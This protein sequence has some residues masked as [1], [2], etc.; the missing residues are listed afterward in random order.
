MFGYLVQRDYFQLL[1][2]MLDEKVPPLD[3]PVTVPP[4]S[5]SETLLQMIVHPLKL[6][7]S[8]TGCSRFILI[9]FVEQIL[10]PS[11][12]DPIRSFVLPCL[13]I[14]PN[15]PFLHLIQFLLSVVSQRPAAP[16]DNNMDTDQA[17]L[18]DTNTTEEELSKKFTGSAFLL[19][20]LLTLDVNRQQQEL[21]VPQ[22]LAIYIRVVAAMSINLN[23]MPAS[24]VARHRGNQSGREDGGV[25]S[26]SD[27]DEEE[28]MVTE[29]GRWATALE[30]NVLLEVVD[31]L[32]ETNRTQLI[33]ES[34]ETH[35]LGE[36]D[37]LH[38]L[39]QI[40]HYLMLFNRAA[41]KDYK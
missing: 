13:A 14:D 19:N 22:N 41:G 30:E 25:S 11:F 9:S 27:S 23:R 20:S 8:C 28:P 39:C 40:C 10:M 26:G 7:D 5:I 34:V 24:K 1:R 29:G 35:F 15:F 3:G 32:N 6:V 18:D 17:P 36:P 4:N 33:C 16:T 38:A 2:Q 21:L 12:S 31:Q 37:V